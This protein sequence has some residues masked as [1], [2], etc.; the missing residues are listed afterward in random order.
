MFKYVDENETRG[1]ASFYFV[2]LDIMAL[3]CYITHSL[4]FFDIA[5][6]DSQ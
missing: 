4:L 5:P 3:F 2:I 6:L 1:H